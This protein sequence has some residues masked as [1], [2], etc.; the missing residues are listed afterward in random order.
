[1]APEDALTPGAPT[2]IIVP[3]PLIASDAPTRSVGALPGIEMF[4]WSV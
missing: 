2:T 1:M 3:S 4:C